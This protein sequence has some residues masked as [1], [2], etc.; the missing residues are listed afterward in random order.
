MVAGV[1]NLQ[2]GT[3]WSEQKSPCLQTEQIPDRLVPASIAETLNAPNTTQQAP[4]CNSLFD[5]HC[6]QVVLQL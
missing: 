2:S 5:L 3:S 6:S 1:R 4:L